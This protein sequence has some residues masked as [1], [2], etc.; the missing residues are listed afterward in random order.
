MRIEVVIVQA[1]VVLIFILL[2]GTIQ[3]NE[4][5]VGVMYRFGKLQE[6]LL[7][8][9]FHLVIPFIND[10]QQVQ[11]SIQTDQIKDIPC[12]TSGGVLINIELIEVVNKLNEPYVFQ[13]VKEYGIDYDQIWIHDKVHHEI[14]QF[15]SKNSLE[16]IYIN[17][18]EVLDEELSKILS[19]Q[20]QKWVPGLEYF[21]KEQR[22]VKIQEAET[23]Q[24]Q[25]IIQANSKL[26]VKKLEMERLVQQK[27]N[28]QKL[29][30]MQDEMY[31]NTQKQIA[32]SKYFSEQKELELMEKKI[33]K[34][35]LERIVL[36]SLTSN[37]KLFIGDQIPSYIGNVQPSQ[38]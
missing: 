9:G 24:K 17:K 6:N 11:V 35:Y 26:E 19:E 29:K 13:T 2:N 20:L 31:L 28:E 16:D 15:C 8:P 22:K 5:N 30:Q 36:D 3:I 38:N 37:L 1:I 34:E 10:I 23:Q 25:Q 7:K 33:S 12:G 4:G 32:D 27:Q 14:N 21:I 18:F